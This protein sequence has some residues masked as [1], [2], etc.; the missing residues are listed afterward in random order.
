MSHLDQPD[1]TRALRLFAMLLLL[2]RADQALTK[3][4]RTPEDSAQAEGGR[5]SGRPP[6][7]AP[8][9]QP[10]LRKQ[11][12]CELAELL[13]RD[14]ERTAT[15]PD[16]RRVAE[17]WEFLDRDQ[18]ARCWWIKAARMGDEDAKDYL[19]VLESESHL[20]PPEHHSDSTEL[21][22]TV[23][24]RMREK[25]HSPDS[26]EG[27][28]AVCEK[29]VLRLALETPLLLSRAGKEEIT[30]EVQSMIREIEEYLASPEHLTD[31]RRL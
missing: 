7:P 4:P 18:L 19:E 22:E 21:R 17:I 3:G 23:M 12:M 1:D 31:G 14:A 2:D 29:F 11:A 24:R 6:A 30:G 16:L 26:K 9:P 28:A 27:K 10:S 20:E 25:L 8:Y 13:H 5:L 15:G